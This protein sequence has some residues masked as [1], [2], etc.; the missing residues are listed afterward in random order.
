MNKKCFFI[1]LGLA[2]LTSACGSSSPGEGGAQQPAVQTK[3]LDQK[4][5]EAVLTKLDKSI[6][7]AQNNFGLQLHQQIAGEQSMSGNLLLSPYSISGALALAYNGSAGE[8]SEEMKQVLGWSGL[9]MDEINE[10]NSQL[11]LLLERGSGVTLNTANSIWIQQEYTLQEDYLARLQDFYKAE[12][13]T[14]DLSS[15]IFVKDINQWVEQQTDGMIKELYEK[16]PD[17]VAALV[18]TIYFNGGWMQTFDPEFTSEQDFKLDDGSLKKVPMMHMEHGFS[19]KESENW[20]A[21]RLP[22]GDGRMHML[23]IVPRESSSLVQLHEQLWKDPSLWEKDYTFEI[24]KLGLP[25]FKAESTL[26]LIDVMK[27]LGMSTATNSMKADFSGMTGSKGLFISEVK[28]K[29]IVDI[30]EEGT[31]AAAVTAVGME[32]SGAPPEKPIEMTADR[33]FFFAI[34]DRDTGAWL[35]MGSVHDPEA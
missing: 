26:E 5:R 4:E 3:P 6:I 19:Y 34:E 24:V 7:K 21:V 35:F 33:P 13:H 28:H 25:K 11:R 12:A 31:E 16:P 29:A 17:I 27:A 18:N 10:G 20:Q 1:L 15:E 22:Y 2:L 8:T 14:A 32:E 9:T 30:D 23:V